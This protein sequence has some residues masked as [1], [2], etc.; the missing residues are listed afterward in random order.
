MYL[1]YKEALNLIE[2]AS[3]GS[4]AAFFHKFLSKGAQYFE[5]VGDEQREALGECSTCGGPTPNEVCAFCKLVERAGGQPV[6]LT[7]APARR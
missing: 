4:K 6:R 3:P 5:P 2:Q 1:R 7:R